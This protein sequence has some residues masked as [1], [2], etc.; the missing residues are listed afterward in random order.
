MLVAYVV[1]KA[2]EIHGNWMSWLQS[3]SDAAALSHVWHIGHTRRWPAQSALDESRVRRLL[4]LLMSINPMGTNCVMFSPPRPA[5]TATGD[6]VRVQS[7]AIQRILHR[8]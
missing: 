2:G 4:P 7:E 1:D 5:P 8:V 3:H 6:D